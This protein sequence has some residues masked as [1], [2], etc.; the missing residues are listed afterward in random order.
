GHEELRGLLVF[1]VFVATTERRQ[2]TKGKEKRT[3]HSLGGRT[4]QVCAG[5]SGHTPLRE[6]SQGSKRN[7]PRAEAQVRSEASHRTL[8]SGATLL[9]RKRTPEL[10][11]PARQHAMGASSSR[12]RAPQVRGTLLSRESARCAVWRILAAQRCLYSG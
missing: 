9:G 11:T 7:A 5:R 8:L 4:A 1:F 6:R 10:H 12:A 2:Q 3:G